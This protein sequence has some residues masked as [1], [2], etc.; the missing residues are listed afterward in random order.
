MATYTLISSNVLSSSA[1]SVTFSA[2]PATY[3]DLVLRASA[4]TDGTG[5]YGANSL[6]IR[7]NGDSSAIYSATELLA[8]YDGSSNLVLSSNITG[9]SYVRGRYLNE[10]ANP[11]NVFGSCELYVPSYTASQSKQVSL[12]GVTERNTA[13][14]DGINTTAGLYT[15][16]TA[17]SSITALCTGADSFVS[18]S[19]FYLYGVSNA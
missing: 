1:A 2:I 15:S 12:S 4:K 19:S 17:I 9:A 7:F 14:I 11:T 16:N 18:G 10:L 3:T 8:T 5:T 13:G 6:L